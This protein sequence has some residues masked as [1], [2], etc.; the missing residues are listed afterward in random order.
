MLFQSAD[1]CVL[2]C[3]VLV[4]YGGLLALTY[5]V[6]QRAPTGFIPQQDQG[7]LIANIQL[8]DSASLERTKAV[9]AKIEKIAQRYARHRAHG[10]LRGHVVSVASEQPQFRLDVHRP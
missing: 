8:P 10:R 2:A 3:V 1:C 5:G 6:F 7:R 4:V 9:V